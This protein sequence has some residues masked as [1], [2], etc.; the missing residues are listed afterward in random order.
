M[1]PVYL[2]REQAIFHRLHHVACLEGEGEAGVFSW[3]QSATLLLDAFKSYTLVLLKILLITFSIFNSVTWMKENIC[4]TQAAYQ[5]QQF[6]TEFSELII[7]SGMLTVLLE[8]AWGQPCITDTVYLIQI[9]VTCNLRKLFV[10]K[11]NSSQ[12]LCFFVAYFLKIVWIFS[13]PLKPLQKN[14]LAYY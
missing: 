8:N 6:H 4:S 11:P 1:S 12:E 10:Q 2:Q 3:L 13:I 9:N 7:K 5:S 14:S